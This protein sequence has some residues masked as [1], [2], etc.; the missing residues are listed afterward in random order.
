MVAT[1][2]G[3]GREVPEAPTKVVTLDAASVAVNAE[4]AT[5]I[6]DCCARLRLADVIQGVT[7]DT[8]KPL[9]ANLSGRLDPFWLITT[10][11]NF[12]ETGSL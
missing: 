10:I 12:P 5:E 9:S 2:V 3:G 8:A 7:E 6:F 11:A 1:P 4:F